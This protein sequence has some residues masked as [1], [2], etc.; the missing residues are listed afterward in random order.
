VLEHVSGDLC[1]AVL[2]TSGSAARL[3]GLAARNLFVVP[4]DGDGRWYRYHR[5][6]AEML[7]AELR[8]R[9]PAEE[10]RLRRPTAAWYEA[11]GQIERAVANA[12]AGHDRAVAARLVTMYGQRTFTVGL[13]IA[14][15]QGACLPDGSATSRCIGRPF[16]DL[17][18][19]RPV[20]LGGPPCGG[21]GRAAVHR[22]RPAPMK[23]MGRVLPVARRVLVG[24]AV[25]ADAMMTIMGV[26]TY[27][28]S[29]RSA[30]CAAS[31]AT[32]S[33]DDTSMVADIGR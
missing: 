22:P 28:T 1:A 16:R 2:D 30:A 27:R 14:T 19:V 17:S 9:E 4:E 7:L 31:A 21:P 23:V 26:R 32:D 6:F 8:R 20:P 3:G 5:L 15:V 12:L 10:L 13:V 18:M 29:P 25:R 33:G 24:D 11:D